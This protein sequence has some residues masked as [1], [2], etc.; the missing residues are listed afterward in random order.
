MQTTKKA[1]GGAASSPIFSKGVH[2]DFQRDS[3]RDHSMPKAVMAFSSAGEPTKDSSALVSRGATKLSKSYPST[4]QR[5]CTKVPA[6]TM[7]LDRYPFGMPSLDASLP[8]L[9]EQRQ[10]LF[11]SPAA[12]TVSSLLVDGSL[13]EPTTAGRTHWGNPLFNPDSVPEPHVSPAAAASAK[14]DISQSSSSARQQGQSA[15]QQP[16]EAD[17]SLATGLSNPADVTWSQSAL[18]ASSLASGLS[19][20][21]GVTQSVPALPVSS[22][23]AVAL[24]DEATAPVSVE[25][26]AV[27]GDSGGAE[28]SMVTGLSTAG[29]QAG[30]IQTPFGSPIAVQ[31]VAALRYVQNQSIHWPVF[32]S[33]TSLLPLGIVVL[34]MHVCIPRALHC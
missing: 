29:P 27:T 22:S 7:S 10:L 2:L 16:Q 9:T 33:N 11:S 5:K 3:H 18:P 1:E 12:K 30:G 13:A 25:A 8:D 19:D 28:P 23:Q 21:A 17:N 20:P 4:P 34:Q 26:A 24:Q 15:Q 32:A 31:D 6:V 14:V